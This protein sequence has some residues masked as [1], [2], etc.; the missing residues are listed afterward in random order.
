MPTPTRVMLPS[1]SIVAIEALEEVKLIDCLTASG[2]TV[3]SGKELFSVR[4]AVRLLSDHS[5]E[6]W[7]LSTFREYEALPAEY[8]SVASDIAEIVTVPSPLRVRVPSSL[9]PATAVLDEE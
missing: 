4:V 3:S 7:H 2:V 1:E 5:T 8:S 6:T 9:I